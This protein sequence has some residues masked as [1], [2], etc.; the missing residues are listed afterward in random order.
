V[1]IPITEVFGPC[2]AE[3]N[4]AEKDTEDAESVHMDDTA[5]FGDT[6]FVSVAALPITED[7]SDAAS[8]E[9]VPPDSAVAESLPSDTADSASLSPGIINPV[10][11]SPDTVA[12]AAVCVFV[13]V[14]SEVL[15]IGTEQPDIINISIIDMQMENQADML[16]TLF[17]IF[18]SSSLICCSNG[19][20]SKGNYGRHRWNYLHISP[21]I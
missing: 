16:K 15:K 3:F 2:E 11:V 18:M 5:P 1:L 19:N 12:P 6:P 4:P 7:C 8:R 20:T 21:F 17:L 14:A 10:S 13:S 9:A